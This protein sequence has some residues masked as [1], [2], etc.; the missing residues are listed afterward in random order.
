MR[1]TGL[2]FHILL[3]GGIIVCHSF[4]ESSNYFS[5]QKSCRRFDQFSPLFVQ[6]IPEESEVSDAE[7]LLACYSYLR[8][9]KRL[10]EWTQQE[11]RQ[12]MKAAASPHFFW[13]EDLAKISKVAVRLNQDAEDA[14]ENDTDDDDDEIEESVKLRPTST[15]SSAEIWSGAFTSFPEDPSPSRRRRSQAAR[16]TWMDPEFREKW[17]QK[18]WGNK[19]LDE[20]RESLE[21]RAL[22]K[23]VRALPSGF[24][25]SEEL[26]SMTEQEIKEAIQSYLKTQK[27][28]VQSRKR[29]LERRKLVLDEQMRNVMT[30]TNSPKDTPALPRDSLLMLDQCSLKEAQQRRSERAK[31]LYQKRIQNRNE[32]EEGSKK[33]SGKHSSTVAKYYPAS[34]TPRDSMIRIIQDLDAGVIPATLDVEIIMKPGKIAKRRDVLRRIL[35]EH[36]DLKGKCV[37]V[38]VSDED[39]AFVTNVSIQDLGAFVISLLRQRSTVSDGIDH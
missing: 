16:R 13:E 20:G 2:P 35:L 25:G 17:Y 12:R 28:R 10:G 7:A 32:K 33:T 23:Q 1:S 34:A 39:L 6:K 9:R 30:Q 18:R 11:R 3:S 4:L 38:G 29:T 19:G 22:E 26:S 14:S 5:L 21:E 31:A 15:S 37:P 8:R 24:L 36:F 27:K